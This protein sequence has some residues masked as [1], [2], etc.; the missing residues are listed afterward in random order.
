MDTKNGSSYDKSKLKEMFNEFIT[1]FDIQN[2]FY[3]ECVGDNQDEEILLFDGSFEEGLNYLDG[4]D[5]DIIKF[6]FKVCEDIKPIYQAIIAEEYGVL[7]D[8][9]N[10]D[11]PKLNAFGEIDKGL[12][13]TDL[14]DIELKDKLL[15]LS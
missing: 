6:F 5:I 3:S 2:N 9:G 13:H 11:S 8:H 12:V 7:T 10:A 15:L 14:E 4:L 1:T